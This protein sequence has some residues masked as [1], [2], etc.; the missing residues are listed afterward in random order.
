MLQTNIQI[1][2][3]DA[4]DV[5]D[6]IETTGRTQQGAPTSYPTSQIEV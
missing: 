1:D 3:I 4:L 5:G 6:S 2:S